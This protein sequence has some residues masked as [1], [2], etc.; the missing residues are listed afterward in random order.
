MNNCQLRHAIPS[1]LIEI[2]SGQLSDTASVQA[3]F[4]RTH[5]ELLRMGLFVGSTLLIELLPLLS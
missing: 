3:L 4:C 5:S 1:R 2:L